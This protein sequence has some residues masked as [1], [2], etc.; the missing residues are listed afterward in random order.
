MADKKPAYVE[1]LRGEFMQKAM[2]AGVEPETAQ[3]LA[4]YVIERSELS[5][6][7]GMKFANRKNQ[8]QSVDPIAA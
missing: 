3:E 1:I 5:F 2:N 6:R 8:N 4:A 7:N